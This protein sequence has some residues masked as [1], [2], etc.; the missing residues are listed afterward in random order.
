MKKGLTTA[1]VTIL[2]LSAVSVAGAEPV[3]RELLYTKKVSISYWP[4]WYTFRFSL[5]DRATGGNMVWSEEKAFWMPIGNTISHYLGSVVPLPSACTQ[6][7]WVQ[8]DLKN[9]TS[10]RA[11]KA[12]ATYVRQGARDRLLIAPYS[13]WAEDCTAGEMLPDPNL[14]HDI[15]AIMEAMGLRAESQFCPQPETRY[16][17]VTNQT[18]PPLFT[19]STGGGPAPISG[20]QAE[21]SPQEYLPGP[22]LQADRICQMEAR[23]AGLPGV[24]KAWLSTNG[25]AGVPES[26]PDTRFGKYFSPTRYVLPDGN[27]TVV[28]Y[29]WDDLTDGQIQNPINVSAQGGTVYGEEG[30]P[31][32]TNTTPGGTP[33]GY[34]SCMDWT[35]YWFPW[36]EPLPDE[37]KGQV[38]DCWDSDPDW[39]SSGAMPCCTYYWA[40]WAEY[41]YCSNPTYARLYCV[42]Q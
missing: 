20:G 1:L 16:V 35:Q 39:T 2:V 30:C 31:V 17:F 15:C 3:K 40:Y 36:A 23:L 27:L 6:Q 33:G 10:L 18:Y 29:G 42:Q 12:R 4:A 41:W 19:Y 11:R 24:Y 21:A 38:G 8:C 34:S 7:L 25:V 13:L 22:A 37:W 14:E 9:Q 28:A 32:W 26:S 5:W